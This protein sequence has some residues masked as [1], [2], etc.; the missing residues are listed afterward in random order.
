M[1]PP[2][3]TQADMARGRT[4]WLVAARIFLALVF[5]A[6]ASYK[7]LMTLRAPATELQRLIA[8]SPVSAYGELA[9]RLAMPHPTFF[10]LLT[11]LFE[12]GVAFSVLLAL[13]ARRA[14]Y[15]AALPFFI[16]LA[17]LIGWFGLTNLTWAVPTLV[18]LRYD[19]SPRVERAG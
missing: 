9:S 17:P 2:S 11:L 8:L 5:V 18:L 1:P 15:G 3:P 7:G 6:G 14:G 10:V 4:R 19:V 16:V 13:P 12:V